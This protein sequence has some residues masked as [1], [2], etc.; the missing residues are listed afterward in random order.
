MLNAAPLPLRRIFA[1]AFVFVA[2]ALP[3]TSEDGLYAIFQTSRGAFTAR[4]DYDK[5]PATVANFVGLVEG[6]RGWLDATTG[7]LRRQPFYTGITFH[8]VESNFMIQAGSPNGLGNDGP[9]Y[10]F[11]DEFHLDLRHDAAGILSMA[12]SGENT[13]G[14]QFFITLGAT[15]GLDNKH[16]VFGRVVEGM[17]VVHAIGAF[18][19]PVQAPETATTIE[20][21]T[22]SRVGTAAQAFD[23]TG[24]WGLPELAD[25]K[26]A[27][28]AEAGKF[29][30]RFGRTPFS[31]YFISLSDELS[32]WTFAMALADLASAPAAD[33]DAT[34]VISGKSRQFFRVVKAGYPQQSATFVNKTLS[35]HLLSSN[36]TLDLAITGEPRG[37]YNASLPLGTVVLDGVAIGNIGAYVTGAGLNNHEFIAVIPVTATGEL[38]ALTFSLKFR[39]PTLGWFTAQNYLASDG[40]WPY[41]GTFEIRTTP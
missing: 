25:A 6:T 10:S 28:V 39:T 2:S 26:P 21:I 18:P 22:I 7:A 24:Q 41:F 4:L 13:N 1:F 5:A 17:D 36:E 9:G 15:P 8:R 12:N 20:S 37:E 14:S 40:L 31:Q 29:L 30:L 3:G 27:L 32:A 16:S 19:T 11:G 33:L 23:A 34:A 38:K 35:L